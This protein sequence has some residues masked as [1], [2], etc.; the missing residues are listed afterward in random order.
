MSGAIPILPGPVPGASRP[1]T[2][3]VMGGGQLGR[4]FVHAAQ[5]MGYAVAVL[6]PDPVS[7]AGRAADVHI[8][9]GYEDEA[10]LA[11]LMQRCEAITTEFENVP[12]AALTTLAAQRPVAPGPHAV[13]VAQDRIAEK[14]HFDRCAAHTGVAPAPWVAIT[15]AEALAQ[16]PDRLLPG[17]LKTARLGYDGKGQISV[18]DRA[19]LAQAWD[20]LHRVPCVLEQRL[21]LRAEYSVILARGADGQ[22]VHYPLQRNWH[23]NGILAVTEVDPNGSAAGPD[24]A[25]QAMAAAEA[26]AAA[27]HYVGV[28]CVEFFVVDDGSST[29]RLVVNE[30][31]PRPHNSGH[32]TIDACD[33]SQFELQVRALAGLPLTAPRLHSA[34]VMLN[35]LGDCWWRDGQPHS[36]DWAR[37]LTLP[38][39][40]LHLYGK[41]QARPG[42]K[43][44]HLTVTATDLPRARAVA[45]Q[46]AQWLG[47]APW[48][49]S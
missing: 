18:E 45:W 8:A 35:L 19:Q 15:N 38:G 34:A 39:V 46:A 1:A 6:D 29:G 27:L 7:P 31:A 4:M 25:A 32:Y 12:A 43:M 22:S 48:P 23:R 30:M 40:H 36:P 3:G 26:I 5:T 42:R 9:T 16:V 13:A 47:M 24:W 49:V 28:L 37:V 10:G 41:L 14:T 21:A 2:L 11:Q 44:G 33:V 20:A 17:I